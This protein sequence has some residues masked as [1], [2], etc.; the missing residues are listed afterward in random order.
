M[1]ERQKLELPIVNNECPICH[2]QERLGRQLIDDLKKEGKLHPDS[3]QEGSMVLNVM[4]ADPKHP[5]KPL[6]NSRLLS[7]P[8]AKPTFKVP[9]MRVYLDVCTEC[10][11]IYCTKFT[12]DYQ[13]VQLQTMKVTLPP[14][15]KGS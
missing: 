14:P 13:D 8:T 9:I 12:L 2:G 3:F 11:A 10:K 6:L 7:N 5:P 15:T 4:L 1:E